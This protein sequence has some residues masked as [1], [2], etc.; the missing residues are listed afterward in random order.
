MIIVYIKYITPFTLS[1]QVDCTHL[2]VEVG[3]MAVLV[4]VVAVLL[5]SVSKVISECPSSG[6][7]L[8][9]YNNNCIGFYRYLPD[10]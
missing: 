7:T 10:A 1:L 9:V 5:L 6:K 3:K 4:L 8:D 2:L